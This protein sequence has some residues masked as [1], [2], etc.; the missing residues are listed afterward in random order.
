MGTIEIKLQYYRNLLFFRIKS[1][2]TVGFHF[3][4][5]AILIACRNAGIETKDFFSWAEKNQTIYF[6]EQLFAAY[7]LWCR[8]NY[9]RPKLTKQELIYGF[10][11]APEKLQKQVVRVWRDSENFGVKQD[12]KKAKASR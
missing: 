8:E 2:L 1:K 4:N 3:W 6:T 10:S 9:K 5:E 11:N 12:K 7:L